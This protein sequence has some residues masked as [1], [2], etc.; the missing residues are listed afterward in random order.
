MI[1]VLSLIS[2]YS[3]NTVAGFSVQYVSVNFSSNKH[4]VYE[5]FS[6]VSY[7]SKSFLYKLGDANIAIQVY[8]N[9]MHSEIMF[10]ISTL[11]SP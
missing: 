5:F 1:L 3:A 9:A 8:K 4:C 2:N 6:K 7:L 10:M 11:L